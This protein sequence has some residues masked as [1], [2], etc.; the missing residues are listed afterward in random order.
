M[1]ALLTTLRRR[2][3]AAPSYTYATWNPD[4]KSSAI[5]LSNGDLTAA[6]GGGWWGVRANI[7]HTDG[8]RY[9]EFTVD[10]SGA[11]GAPYV[12]CGIGSAAQDLT[13]AGENGGLSWAVSSHG[14]S[15]F[16]GNYS[17][18]GI[19][20]DDGAVIGV[21]VLRGTS[22]AKFYLINPDGSIGN[23]GTPIYT[24]DMT[25]AGSEA[26]FIF[27]SVFGGTLTINAGATPFVVSTVPD[28]CDSGWYTA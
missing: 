20:L 16:P 26:M 10:D 4:D 23:S 3:A 11:G 5:D 25:A 24:A 9:F 13:Y 1:G 17:S 19:T 21:A 7:S 22:E 14:Y 15:Y 28:S 2:S 12:M 27:G 18:N 6:S 8:S